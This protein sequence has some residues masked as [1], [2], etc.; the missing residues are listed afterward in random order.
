MDLHKEL[1][2]KQSRLQCNKIVK[3][4]GTDEARFGILMEFFLRGD[5]RLAQ[6]A[7]WPV[8]YCIHDHLALA[9]PYFKKFLKLLN[10]ANSHPAVRRN[11]MRLFQFVEIPKKF[12]GELM[13]YCFR[14]INSPNEAIA[15]KAFSLHILENMSVIYPEILPELK[16]IIETRWESESPA[17]RSRAR[18]ILKRARY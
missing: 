16:T 2:K 15:V 8:S 18:K 3:W 4:I 5:Y 6:Y 7:A 11:I 1:L 10:D 17:F 13:D 14:F 9:K 12:N